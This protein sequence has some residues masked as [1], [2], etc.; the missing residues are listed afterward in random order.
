MCYEIRPI[1][2]SSHRMSEIF[3]VGIVGTGSIART[4]YVAANSL[5]EQG[6]IVLLA[7]QCFDWI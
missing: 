1:A 2:L 4:H 7:L 3:G 6:S 5:N